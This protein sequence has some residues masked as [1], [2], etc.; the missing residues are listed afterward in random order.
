MSPARETHVHRYRKRILTA[1]AGIVVLA[2][3]LVLLSRIFLPKD[4]TK[5]AGME[6]VFANGILGEKENTIDVLGLGDSY[7]Y[8]S[9]IPPEI[10]KAEGYTSY[11]A[12]TNDQSL[13]YTMEMLR[14]V[15]QRQNP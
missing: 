6:E 9:T 4:N 14:R 11:A 2:L 8:F 3:A 12:G 15:Y 7:S 5:E 13:D 1:C 10:W